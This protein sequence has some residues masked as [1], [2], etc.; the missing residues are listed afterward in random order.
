MP[1]HAARPD[2]SVLPVVKERRPSRATCDRRIRY[3]RNAY[4]AKLSPGEVLDK[5]AASGK[6]I[7]VIGE[8]HYERVNKFYHWAFGEMKKKNPALD[9]ILVEQPLAKYQ[10][11]LDACHARRG[12]KRASLPSFSGVAAGLALGLKVKAIDAETNFMNLPSDLLADLN[13]RDRFMANATEDLFK[14]GECKFALMIIGANHARGY[15]RETSVVAELKAKNFDPYKIELISP[16]L[17][18]DGCA[19]FRWRWKSIA[20]KKLC[21]AEMP[22]LKENFGFLNS[23]DGEIVPSEYGDIPGNDDTRRSYGY[24]S[25]YDAVIALGCKDP[26][27]SAC[28]LEI[29]PDCRR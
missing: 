13:R 8:S 18:R 25:D 26:E 5:A 14:S 3:L 19:D 22:V 16:G 2:P 7:V 10:A 9:C 11:A 24:W 15:D 21:A 17:N 27:A 29:Y 1:A 6:K 12:C 20:G 4:D 28:P 23:K